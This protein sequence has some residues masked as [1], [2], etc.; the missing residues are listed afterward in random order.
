V[1]VGGDWNLNPL[2][3]DPGLFTTG[4]VGMRIKP[5][6]E[7]DFLPKSWKWAFN[8][9][10][11]TNRSVDQPY[12]RGITTTTIIDF[13]VVSPNIDVLEIGTEDLGFQW[14]DHQPVR[15]RFMLL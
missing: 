10:I 6:I 5:A 8:P 13:F 9:A 7:P 4:D 1:V 12:E 15:M 14:S 2:G 3:F 11:P